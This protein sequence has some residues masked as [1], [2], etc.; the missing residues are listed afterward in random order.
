MSG[1]VAFVDASWLSTLSLLGNQIGGGILAE[2]AARYQLHIT[3]EVLFELSSTNL[4]SSIRNWLNDPNNFVVDEN[5]VTSQLKGDGAVTKNAGDLS[6]Y[7]AGKNYPGA[8]VF[9]DDGFA[10]D[11]LSGAKNLLGFI[12]NKQ[13]S[14]YQ[15]IKDT[16]G[17]IFQ[18]TAISERITSFGSLVNFGG[19][20]DPQ[21]F[22]EAVRITS[23]RVKYFSDEVTVRLQSLLGRFLGDDTGSLTLPDINGAQAVRAFGQ[24]LG[25]AGLAA[26]AYDI[27]TSTQQALAQYRNNDREGALATESGMLGRVLGGFYG[28]E[29]GMGAGLFLATLLFPPGALAEL[30]ILVAALIGAYFGVHAGELYL[31]ANQLI[32]RDIGVALGNLISP[33]LKLLGDPLILD[34][35]GDGVRTTSLAGSTVHF[36]YNV[37]GFAELTGW[38]SPDDGILAIDANGNG[39]IDSAVELFGSATQDG[40]AVLETFDANGDG[41]IDAADPVFA[42]LRV[43]RDLN[44]NGVSD[45]G[46]LQTL[47]QAGIK[48]ISLVRQPGSGTDAGNTIGYEAVFTRN[49]GTTGI[50]Q[51]IYFQTDNRDTR[52]DTT[53]DFTIADGVDLLPL[54]PG[55]G[56]IY[57]IAYKATTESEFRGAWTSLTDQASSM[58]PAELRAALSNLLLQWAGVSGVDPQSRGQFVDAR[59]LAF[60]EA[61]FG[62]PYREVR[63][64]NELRTY[65]GSASAGASIEASFESIIAVLEVAFLAQQARSVVARG[66]D[67]GAAVSSPYFFYSMLELAQPKPGDP[68]PNTPGNIGMVVDL[69]AMAVPEHA[70]AAVAYLERALLGLDGMVS[71]AFSGDRSGYANAV[72]P[73]LAGVSDPVMHEITAHIVDGSALVGTLAAEGISGTSNQDVFIGG[74]GGDLL[75]GGDGSDIYVYSKQD[76]DLWIKDYGAAT[77]TDRLV[78]T[79]INAGDVTFDRIGDDLLM[80]ITST[81]KTVSVE[82]FFG[83]NG[84]DVIRFADGTEWGRTQ[85]E[86]A[87]VYRGDGHNNAIYD[88]SSDDVIHGGKGDDFIRISAGNDTIFYAKGDGYDVVEDWS[89]V[90][91]ENDKLVLTDL[92]ASDIQLSRVGGHLILTVKATGEYIDFDN[93][94]PVN[95]GDWATTGR[96]IDTIQFA[97]GTTWNRAQIQQNAWYRGTDRADIIGGSEL[98]DTIVGGKGDDIL[99]GGAGND[100]F[101][102]KMGDGNDQISDASPRTDVDTLWLTDVSPG[103]VSYSYQGNTLLITIKPTGEI[104]RVIDF[105]S[106]VTSLLTGEGANNVGIDQIRF[107]DGSIASRQQ[108]TYQ[109]G[110]DYMGRNPVVWTNVVAGVITWQV[111]VDEFGHSGNIVGHGIDGI[112]DIWNASSYG[113]YGG[114]LGIPDA[115]QPNPFHGGGNNV[116]NGGSGID[117]L[118]GG[119]GQDVLSGG[120]GNDILYGDYVDPSAPGG[121]DIIDAGKGDDAVYGGPGMDLIYGGEGNDFLSGGDGKDFIYGSTGNDTFVGGKGDD[122]LVANDSFTSGSDTFIYARGDGNDT[123][124]ESGSTDAAA[125]SDVLVLSDLASDDVE[126]SRAGNDL[127]VKIKSTGEII[128][129]VGQFT[130]LFGS[131][132]A[133]NGAGIET[134]RFLDG[135]WNRVKIQQA[136]WYRGTDGRDIINGTDT[137]S[138]L[139]ST[140]DGGRGNDI[141]YGGRGSDTFVYARGDG[142]DTIIDGANNGSAPTAVD[143]LKF[144]DLNAADV[145]LSRSGDDLLIKVLGT[146]EVITVI[147]QFNGSLT[148][149]DSALERI[150]FADGTQLDRLQMQQ[151]AWYRGTDGNDA[152]NLSG[153]N[154]TV[155]GGKGDDIIYSGFQS[156]SGNDTFVYSRGDGND[157]IREQTWP[158]FGPTEID[159]LKFRDIYSSDISLRRSGN[160]LLIKVLSTNETITILAQFNDSPDAPGN[161][162]EYIQ[163]ANGDQWGRETI[164]SIAESSSPFIV[165]GNGNDHLVGSGADQNL[166]GEAGDDT[167]D[168]QGGSDLLYGGVGNDT[169]VLS[170]S[171]AGDHVTA[172]GGVGTDTLDLSG[173]GAA[174]WV[175]LVTNGAEV[176]TTDQ[177]NLST[178]EWR[179]MADVANVENI[180][181]TV[182]ADQLAGDAGNNVILGDA[183]DDVIDGRS[184]DDRLSGGDGN[185]VLTG[186][187]GADLLDGGEGADVL[188]GGLG[189]DVLIGGAGNDVL[190]GGTESDIFVFGTNSGSDTITDFTAGSGSAHDVIRFDRLVFANYAAVIA[191]A[192]QV[193]SDV[194]IPL[195]GGNSVTLQNV[196]L[197]DLTADNFEFRRLDNQAPTGITVTGGVVNEGAAAG[198]VVATLGAI[199]PNDNG[200]HTFVLSD[201]SGLFELVGNEIRVKSGA[202]VDFEQASQYQ[203]SVSTTDDDG[204]SAVSTVVI[205]VADQTE[206]ATGTAGNDVVTGGVGADILSGGLGDDRL[207]GGGGSDEYRYQL[208]DGNDRI[209]DAGGATDTDKLVLGAG[210]DPASVV[211]GHSSLTTSDLVLLL[212]DGSTIVL[213][214]QLSGTP[215]AGIEQMVFADGTIWDRATLL[216]R[217]TPE[218]II[219]SQGTSTLSGGGGRDVLEAGSGD[220]TLVGLGGSDVYRIQANAGNDTITEGS[221]AGT[222]RIELVGMTKSDLLF[223]R[224]GQDLVI[225][226]RST[227]RII[228]VAGQFASTPGGVEEIAFSDGEV[229]DRGQITLYA[230]IRTVSANG[231]VTGTAG[232]DVLQPGQGNQV[233]QGGAGNDTVIYARGDGSDTIND[234]VNAAGQIDALRFVDLNAAD[235]AFALQGADLTIK[236]L[237]TGDIITVKQQFVSATDYSGLEQIVFADGTVWDRQAI[238]E[239]T[240][241]KGTS[242]ND[243]LVGTTG[244]D[245]LEGLA[246]DDTLSGGNGNDYL[247]GGAGNDTISGNSGDDTLIGGEG[248]DILDGSYGSDT[249]VYNA[250]DGND[251][252]KDGESYDTTVDKLVL[253][254]GL[255]PSTITISRSGND[256]K[257]TFSVG[258]SVNLVNEDVG[259]ASGI[260][261]IVFGDGTVW[262]K[263]DLENAFLAQQMAAGATSI[264]GFNQN[265]DVIVG[266]SGADT[267]SG[268]GGNDTLTGGLGDDILDGGYNS[269]TFIYNAGDGNDTILEGQTYDTTVDKLVLGAGLT[270]STTTISRNGNDIKLT[271]SV[272]G[273]VNL[274]N[275]DVGNA[276][277]IEQIVFGDGTVWSKQGL[278]NAFLAQQMAAGATSITGFNQNSDVI[279]GTSGADTLSGLGGNDTLTGGRGDDQLDGGSGADT[280][281]YS[282]GDGKDVI[283]EGMNY[284]GATDKLV[285]SGISTSR[286]SVQRDGAEAAVIVAESSAGAG[287]GGSIRLRN[288]FNSSNS[289]GVEQIILADGTVW[290]VANLQTLATFADV[291]GDGIVSGTSGADQIIVQNGKTIQGGSGSDTYRYA[292]GS[293]SGLIQENGASSD[294]DV[295]VFDTLNASDLTFSRSL[296]DLNDVI[297]VVNATGDRITIDNQISGAASGIESIMFADGTAWDAATIAANAWIRGTNGND[298]ITLPSNGVNV[299]AGPG[300]DRLSVS[301]TGANRIVFKKG[302]GHDV[303]DNTGSGYQRSDQL[304]LVDLLPSDVVLSR[305]GNQLIVSVLSTGDTFTALWQFYNGG[306]SVYGLSSIKFAD[307]TVWD[308]AAIA[309]AANRT[310]ID[311]WGA[312]RVVQINNNYALVPAA[313]GSGPVLY[314][315]SA[316]LTVGQLAPWTMLGAEAV[317]GGY[318][319]AWKN[320]SAGLVAIWNVDASG[321]YLSTIA[322]AAPNSA[323]IEAYEPMFRQDLNGDGTIGF[324]GSLVESHGTTSVLQIGAN[325]ALVPSDGSSGSVL[326]FNGALLTADQLA[327]W[328]L[329]GAERVQGGYD[330]AW[331]NATA[332]LVAIWSVDGSGNYMSTVVSA[333]PNSASIEAYEP[334]LQ[335]DLNGDGTIGFVGT[336]VESYGTTSVLQ[337]G[338][339]FALVPSDGGSGT[340]LY[341]NGAPLTADQLVPWTLLGAERVQGGYNV[342]CKNATAGLVAIWSVDANGNYVS[343]LVSAAPTSSAIQSYETLFQQDLTGDGVIQPALGAMQNL[344]QSALVSTDLSVDPAANADQPA[345]T[346]QPSAADQSGQVVTGTSGS[347]TLWGTGGDE[348]FV[349]GGGDDIFVGGGGSDRY[350][351]G[352][353]AGALTILNG[354]SGG[355]P[356]GR[357]EFSEG[358]ADTNLWL[359]QS[360]DNL[361]VDLLGTNSKVTVKDWFSVPSSQLQ[362][363]TAGGLK[364]DSQI[365]QLV[366]AMASYSS[367]HA[368]FD[369]TSSSNQTAPDDPALQ[370]SIA[371]A[372][373]A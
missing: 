172:D 68:Q 297:V 192:Q 220:R 251:T 137:L 82:S 306:S 315:N 122:V 149:S 101:I 287:D 299:E 223:S 118:A 302:D 63:A 25:A 125:E 30:T 117:I 144:T 272:G 338:A 4:A 134:I 267:L 341:F 259:N 48:S 177:A 95:T 104:I 86:H 275:E 294:T 290:T 271:F 102:W 162:L 334:I 243:T 340:V 66:G 87:S 167:I 359:V 210:I 160:D 295:L 57:S 127:L 52:A 227:A 47:A 113:G 241:I 198:T 112:N 80:R 40:F 26:A 273:S 72:L 146:G 154:D 350:L 368:G 156:G 232:D 5:P 155:E 130:Y 207:V 324:V 89:G 231:T 205:T 201:A 230:P 322:S 51:T 202:I 92:N 274:V 323:S 371:A 124:Y 71:V 184:G 333:A 178:G 229:W 182:Y 123:I 214:N 45:D 141:V 215:G 264:T 19:A 165:G 93:F 363:I 151:Q 110:I 209:V 283:T 14:S 136:A 164:R 226:N 179:D 276:S 224:E 245:H 291:N 120:D 73:H 42:K 250:G 365:S 3:R 74:G 266:T 213:E 337:I 185:D 218:L 304:E 353:D 18:K 280:F 46:E 373:H 310:T 67:I 16:F 221:E 300:D 360:G 76:G 53:P 187:M 288:E 129:V 39:R 362:E 128:T 56:T 308:V 114:I 59:H 369:P 309:E 70:G 249:F 222:D 206:T 265:S 248:D 55:S 346:A 99:E 289:Q 145:E 234:G 7:E 170:V 6:I 139:D 44:Q 133:V 103:D 370:A 244:N 94:F 319:V 372:W 263:Q 108:I 169:L 211:V 24:I 153:L 176:R 168:G 180:T 60:V 140:F 20:I 320:A 347:D 281:V 196:N 49:D 200:A 342:A 240:W 174:V 312:T 345:E 138:Q 233:I 277:G 225:R 23:N 326:Y 116:L 183:G 97:D 307:G 235:L 252:V 217:L 298:S 253:G 269:D 351:F 301:G 10:A 90:K 181:G 62:Q 247:S 171:N 11:V 355:A 361:E 28:A 262:S 132:F 317:S 256:I 286:I 327:P 91:S 12:E 237:S 157:V 216:Q 88:S 109:A 31:E 159:T 191:A 329:L 105:F 313:G 58:T 257:L 135:D 193:G 119:D 332:G 50:A 188:N 84:V 29:L 1:Q 261:Q 285:L 354:V 325:F 111:F 197:V 303:L 203:V 260:E 142:S 64:G 34:L 143:T 311:A 343:T 173:F 364:I 339:N 78:L 147:S 131:N 37:D 219:G 61:F 258:G 292:A 194:V 356:S 336:L 75:S 358:I 15:S 43:W 212:T 106:G 85:I 121:N 279:V 335:Q 254:A 81:G 22:W 175:D 242:G 190:T 236:V 83:G 2:Q 352:S 126:M 161:G 38:V 318:D 96:N 268:L 195:G 33:L 204:L 17:D 321:N 199:D 246:G 54:L 98:D 107:Q 150:V 166:Y 331:K 41:V 100:T 344:V 115:L 35:N 13:A 305:S 270:P 357:L 32:G 21:S 348:T 282:S 330:V 148:G 293:G 65:P 186:G 189:A 9:M 255:T 367:S 349:G 158:S 316:P 314:F 278:E 284:D 238:T 163:F 27:V 239:A 296:A 208:G 69:I 79:D 8:K 328:T 228:T 77:D 152:I 366:Q 36:D